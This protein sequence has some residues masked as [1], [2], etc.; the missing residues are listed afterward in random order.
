MTTAT[1]ITSASENQ[2]QAGQPFAP[3]NPIV[4]TGNASGSWRPIFTLT[5]TPSTGWGRSTIGAS[6]DGVSFLPIGSIEVAPGGTGTQ[7]QSFHAP[8]T[9]RQYFT[10]TAMTV[11]PGATLTLTMAY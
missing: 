2:N 9:A 7:T 6:A 1:L 4:N 8:L 5:V 11:S 3:A 10:A